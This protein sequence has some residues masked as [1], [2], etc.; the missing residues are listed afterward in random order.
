MPVAAG[1]PHGAAWNGTIS[2]VPGDLQ[3]SAPG[4]SDAGDQVGS[5]MASTRGFG[6]T[7]SSGITDARAGTSWTQLVAMST[8]ELTDLRDDLYAVGQAV[9]VSALQYHA[10]DVSVMACPA[11]P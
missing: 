7:A 10:T 4:F 1:G 8:A 5:A 9:E 3:V 2:V 6:D 11:E